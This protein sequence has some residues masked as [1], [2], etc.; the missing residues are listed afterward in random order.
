MTVQQV[1]SFDVVQTREI[2]PD[3]LGKIAHVVRYSDGAVIQGM[4][5]RYTHWRSATPAD[6][7]RVKT[8]VTVAGVNMQ[9]AG[10]DSFAIERTEQ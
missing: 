5:T 4:L 6:V 1:R 10:N 8:E 2:S 7:G 3:H 9:L